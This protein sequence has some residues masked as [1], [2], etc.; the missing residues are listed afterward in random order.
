M[1]RNALVAVMVA[2]ACSGCTKTWVCQADDFCVGG[3]PVQGLPPEMQTDE[4][5]GRIEVQLQDGLAHWGATAEALKGWRV[6]YQEGP[7]MED[8]AAHGGYADYGDSTITLQLT[9]PKCIERAQLPHE[10]GH[11]VLRDSNHEDPRW[12]TFDDL[13]KRMVALPQCAPYHFTG[14]FWDHEVGP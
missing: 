5:R 3:I 11:A 14:D 2:A 10:I 7:V 8:G 13:F 1:R 4:T 9:H 6:V 12:R